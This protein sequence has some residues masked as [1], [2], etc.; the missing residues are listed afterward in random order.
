MHGGEDLIQ[1]TMLLLHSKLKQK[2]QDLPDEQI[3]DILSLGASKKNNFGERITPADKQ[4]LR[5]IA[6]RHHIKVEPD[7]NSE[8]TVNAWF[9]RKIREA[10]NSGDTKG[11]QRWQ[12]MIVDWKDLDNKP[13]TPDNIIIRNRNDPNDLYAIDGLRLVDRNRSVVKRGVY[14]LFP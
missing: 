14:D 9:Q 5:N 4:A 2:Y 3:S 11:L 13:E 12:N 6:T 1:T 7:L 10:E 8:V